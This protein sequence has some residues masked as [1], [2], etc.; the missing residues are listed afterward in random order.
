MRTIAMNMSENGHDPELAPPAPLF[1][2]SL[3]ALLMLLR[4]EI[5][6]REPEAAVPQASK[7][8]DEDKILN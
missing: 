6:H 1:A 4:A 8:V 5:L 2:S 3:M 7:D